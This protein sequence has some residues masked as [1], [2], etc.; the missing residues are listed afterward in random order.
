MFKKYTNKIISYCGSNIQT[1]KKHKKKS[2][3]SLYMIVWY[4]ID[5]TS[6]FDREP[7]ITAYPNEILEGFNTKFKS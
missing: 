6:Y 3:R 5:L 2:S 7:Y 4:N 1:V